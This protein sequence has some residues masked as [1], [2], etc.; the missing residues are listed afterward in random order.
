V[1]YIG[2]DIVEAPPDHAC[3][4]CDRLQAAANGPVVPPA[5]MLAGGAFVEVVSGGAKICQ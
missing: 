3:F 5:V 1:P 4:F 2:D